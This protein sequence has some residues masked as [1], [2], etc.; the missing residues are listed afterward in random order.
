MSA[1]N[2]LVALAVHD[3]PHILPLLI[4]EYIT[5]NTSPDKR[6]KLGE[7]L[8]RTSQ[9]LGKSKQQLSIVTEMLPKTR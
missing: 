8:V 7:A 9:A 4:N 5:P 6:V 2:G 3:T 1:I